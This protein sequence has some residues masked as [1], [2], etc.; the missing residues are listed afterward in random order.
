[1]IVYYKNIL[2]I[3][4]KGSYEFNFEKAL[5]E[6]R[7]IEKKTPL[8]VFNELMKP[9]I[10]ESRKYA[11]IPP[12]DKVSYGRNTLRGMSERE[13]WEAVENLFKEES[14]KELKNDKLHNSKLSS[15]VKKILPKK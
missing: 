11:K 7:N 14:L 13:Y 10:E 1:M 8:E 12:V 2:K 4:I 5:K 3:L 6:D 9:K 15:K